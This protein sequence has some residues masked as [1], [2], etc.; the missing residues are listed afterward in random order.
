MHKHSNKTSSTLPVAEGESGG[1]RGVPSPGLHSPRELVG[2]LEA[3]TSKGRLTGLPLSSVS[4]RTLPD[5]PEMSAS[6]QADK[7]E[8]WTCLRSHTL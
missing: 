1:V 2:F 3:V 7:S 5:P 8:C 6:R 4:D